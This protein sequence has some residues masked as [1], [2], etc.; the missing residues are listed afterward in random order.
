M[1]NNALID[2]CRYFKGEKA[3][4]NNKPL[5]FWNY[6]KTWVEMNKDGAFPSSILEEYLSYGM[7]DFY[8]NDDTPITLKAILYNRF[9]SCVGAD[10]DEFDRWYIL[11]YLKADSDAL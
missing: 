9:R 5:S 3:C 4:P 2:Q 11:E 8:P 7:A 10:R 6:E 1:A